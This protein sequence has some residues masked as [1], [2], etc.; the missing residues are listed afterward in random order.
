MA[1][2]FT[3]DADPTQPGVGGVGPLH[4]PPPS[5]DLHINCTNISTNV[6]R[7]IHTQ[8]TA[9]RSQPSQEFRGS[10]PPLK[11]SKPP[12]NP[13]TFPTVAMKQ[14]LIATQATL[15]HITL[16][17]CEGLFHFFSWWIKSRL[18]SSMNS[19]SGAC[20]I[21]TA[22]TV[23]E[24]ST[25]LF[26]EHA[27][28]PRCFIL[29]SLISTRIR[30]AAQHLFVEAQ[31]APKLEEILP[32]SLL[33]EPNNFNKCTQILGSETSLANLAAPSKPP[34][35]SSYLV[36]SHDCVSGTPPH[37]P[38]PCCRGNSGWSSMGTC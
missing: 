11:K 31:K 18:K 3:P 29:K 4:H 8:D 7:C 22:S 28:S 1:A 16:S 13:G 5:P 32:V 25:F 15:V 30:I 36:P 9:V 17:G 6:K 27:T 35:I 34:H 20:F 24:E 12:E 19:S 37:Q 33:F 10:P 26:S 14:E 21:R 2:L 38:L 23:M